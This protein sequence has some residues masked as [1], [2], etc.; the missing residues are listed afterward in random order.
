M[1][2]IMTRPQ[3]R[4]DLVSTLR[5][6][7]ITR[8]SKQKTCT[9]VIMS[10]KSHATMSK[11]RIIRIPKQKHVLLSLCQKSPM[12]LCQNY[13]L[14]E[15]HEFLNKKTCT[16]VIMSE[17]SHATISKL[18]IIR[19][20]RIPKQK[21]CTFVIMSEKSHATISILRIIRIIRIPKQKNMNFCHYVRKVP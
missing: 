20:T 13:E 9:F 2:R 14:Y 7:R 15:L 3:K 12:P 21:T 1:A 6:I 4:H 16:F 18:R 8:I 19:I 11:L 5:I 10:E 17:K